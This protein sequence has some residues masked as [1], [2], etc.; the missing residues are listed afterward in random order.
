MHGHR[1]SPSSNAARSHADAASLALRMRGEGYAALI[2]EVE[3]DL[4]SGRVQ[5]NAFCGGAGLRSDLEPGRAP[6]SNRGRHTARDESC[7]QR[8][9]DVG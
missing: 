9:S 2:A 6:Q 8:R 7:C 3:I 4:A 5:A 1:P